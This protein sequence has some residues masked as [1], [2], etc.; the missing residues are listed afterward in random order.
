MSEQKQLRLDDETMGTVLAAAEAGD[1]VSAVVETF[2]P[3]GV[4]LRDQEGPPV[5]P[6]DYAI[7]TDQWQAICSALIE[8]APDS[9][10]GLGKA[11][12]GMDWV[13]IGPSAYEPSES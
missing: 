10:S 5:S 6:S 8:H 4:D 12:R 11:N 3:F 13:N 2:R 1:F 7:P 9:G